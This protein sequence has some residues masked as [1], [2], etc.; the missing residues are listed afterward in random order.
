MDYASK[1]W[2]GIKVKIYTC[3]EYVCLLIVRAQV[4]NRQLLV[5]KVAGARPRARGRECRLSPL[6]GIHFVAPPMR[7]AFE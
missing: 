6:R 5:G 2:L 4:G 1:F 3:C 7:L